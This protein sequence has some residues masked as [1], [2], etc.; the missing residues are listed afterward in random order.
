MQVGGSKKAQPLGRNGMSEL[1][2]G[3]TSRGEVIMVTLAAGEASA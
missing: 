1:R 2:L 3:I